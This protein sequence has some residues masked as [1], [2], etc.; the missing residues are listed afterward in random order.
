MENNVIALNRRVRRDAAAK[1]PCAGKSIYLCSARCVAARAHTHTPARDGEGDSGAV[2]KVP[3]KVKPFN[4]LS[5]KKYRRSMFMLLRGAEP[6]AATQCDDASVFVCV[7]F[8]D[9]S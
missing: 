5:Y 2:N 4:T 6:A 1:R 9:S 3:A 8:I 7:C